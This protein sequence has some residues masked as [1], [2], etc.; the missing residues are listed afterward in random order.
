MQFEMLSSIDDTESARLKKKLFDIP[1]D[2][3]QKGR[4][5]DLEEKSE[6]ET[7][8]SSESETSEDEIDIRKRRSKPLKRKYVPVSPLEVARPISKKID[9][10][11]TIKETPEIAH[12]EYKKLRIRMDIDQPLLENFNNCAAGVYEGSE[13]RLNFYD[14][15]PLV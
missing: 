11:G 1:E 15:L 8:S 4:T 6:S 14:R 2:S 7:D 10:V 9:T 13:E 3:P 5:E 12:M